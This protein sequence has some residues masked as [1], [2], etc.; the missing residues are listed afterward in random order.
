MP[1]RSDPNEPRPNSIGGFQL[2]R[3]NSGLGRA[4]TTGRG[5]SVY[6]DQQP[7]NTWSEHL[8]D[9]IQ[10]VIAIDNVDAVVSWKLG[11][12]QERRGVTGQFV[13]LLPSAVPHAAEWLGK[14]GMVVLYVDPAFARE[15]CGEGVIVAHVEDYSALARFNLLVSE[16][17]EEFRRLCR[18][19]TCATPAIVESAGTLLAIRILRYFV[20]GEIQYRLPADRLRDVLDH[21]DAHIAE[22][23][24][25]KELARIA[26]MSVRT[27]GECFKERTGLAPFD[28]LWQRRTVGAMALVDEGKLTKTAIAADFGFSDQSHMMRRI[29]ALREAQRVEVSRTEEFEKDRPARGGPKP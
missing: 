7:P 10:I 9:Q 23:I 12:V 25:R 16:L 2:P 5:V 11:D 22:D 13:W 26:G 6:Y 3:S 17:T 20:R 1:H 4:L 19:K 24:S 21:F 27:F 15:V 8:H 29:D 28:Y 18:G 14:A